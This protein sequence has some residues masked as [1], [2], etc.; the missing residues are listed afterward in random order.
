MYMA[1]SP[2]SVS[3][4]MNDE[5]LLT[6]EM[7]INADKFEWVYYPLPPSQ[8]SN[9]KYIIN[10]GNARYLKLNEKLYR[11]DRTERK[12]STL[13]VKVMSNS[14]AGDYQC[15]AYYGASV[16]ASVP[17]RI[18]ITTMGRY[19]KQETIYKTVTA[20][21]TVL[22]RCEPPTSNPPAY[23]DYYM[24]N[25]NYF[26]LNSDDPKTTSLILKNVNASNSGEYKCSA[27]NIIENNR[28]DS[29]FSLNLKVIESGPD[30]APSFIIPPTKVYTVEKGK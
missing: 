3:M 1:T 19:P 12:A 23:I 17:G 28:I 14:M 16:V 11:N 26:P 27:N 18:T 6:C 24:K 10:L 13:T 30:T 9:P 7:N 22:W 4:P 5:T 29:D 2:N 21:N 25:K 20:G 15:L 8:V